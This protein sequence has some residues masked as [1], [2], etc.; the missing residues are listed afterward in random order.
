MEPQQ[1]EKILAGGDADVVLLARAALREPSWPLRAAAELGLSWRD[2][3]YPAAYTRGRWDDVP[4]ADREPGG[5]AMAGLKRPANVRD[6]TIHR[7]CSKENR[8]T[9]SAPASDRPDWTA[10]LISPDDDFA[11]APLLR[12]EFALED[13]HGGI[14]S[15]VLHATAHGVF[16]A[17]LNGAPVGDDVL[18]P[19]WSSYEWR[20]RYRTYEV[21]DLL[22]PAP[23]SPAVLGFALGNGW[24]RGRLG[25]SGGRGYYGDELGVLA[26]LEITYADGHRA[27]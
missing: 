24:Y 17:Y 19:G 6:E 3:P 5:Q 9:A 14:T 2:A 8:M 23:S 22:H 21:T 4:A 1:A 7:P 15:A 13:G 20:L 16:Q 25:W 12:T 27:A 10:R 11:G 26:Q 18:S